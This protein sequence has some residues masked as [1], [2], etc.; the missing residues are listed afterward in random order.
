MGKIYLDNAATSW[1]KPEAVYLAVNNFNRNLGSS[2][3]RGSTSSSLASTKLVLNAR[4]VVAELFHIDNP[5]Q[6]AF[7][8]NVTEALN[9]VIKGLLQPG[10]HLIISSMEHNALA[11][12]AHVISQT[13]V[14]VTIVPCDSMGKLDVKIL[15]GAIKKN[16]K[17]VGLSHASN[18]TGAIQPIEQVGRLCKEAGILFVLDSAQSAGCLPIDVERQYIDILTFTGHKGLF[19][20][21]GTGGLYCRSDLV[22]PPLKTGGTGSQSESFSQPTFMPDSLESGTLNT[23]GIVGLAAGIEFIQEK[24]IGAIRSHECQLVTI[25]LRG[26][27]DI[28]KVQV[29]GPTTS[30]DRTSVVSFTIGELDSGQ[31]SY[32]LEKEFEIVTRAGLHCS[33]LAHQTIGT[34]KQ[35]TCRIS[36]GYF[37]TERE[38][39]IAINAIAEI[40]SR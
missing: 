15:A 18:V 25:L 34:L 10:D 16:T 24:G 7:M 2:P 12:P 21:Q 30:K 39:N 5:L 36:P 31:V 38:M 23:P 26:L 14:E 11:R 6:I 37:N 32:L 17:M 35:G 8:L 9:V 22:I 13:G 33:P 29:Y 19:G 20:P 4:E 3:G 1:P 27:Q 28:E 40:A